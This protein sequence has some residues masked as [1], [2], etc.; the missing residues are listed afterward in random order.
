MSLAG[1]AGLRDF[2]ATSLARY[3]NPKSFHL[4]AGLPRNSG[5]KVM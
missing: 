1:R 5:G 2:C 4:V 3:K